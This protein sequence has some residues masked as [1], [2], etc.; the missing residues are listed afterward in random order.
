MSMSSPMI[1]TKPYAV[2]AK[3]TIKPER[4]KDFLSLIKDN[5]EKTLELEPAA[6]QYVVGED[7]DSPNTFHIHEEFMDSEGFDAHRAMPHAGDWAAFKNSDPFC[8]GGEV[9]LDFYHAYGDDDEK[10]DS[11]IVIE[12]VPIRPAFC[13]HVELCIKPEIRE[14]FLEVIKNNQKGSNNEELCL[15]YMFGESTSEENKFVF[16]EEYTGK[17]DGRDRLEAHTKAPHFEVWEK[18]VEKDP[19][20]KTP[21]V[22][23]FKTL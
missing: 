10:E 4:R 19:F 18:F 8:E 23:F 14:E 2:N 21:V 11:S 6:L 20:T 13:V 16:H 17:D 15:Q 9:I 7:V 5:Q 22:N 1:S 12:K 3:F